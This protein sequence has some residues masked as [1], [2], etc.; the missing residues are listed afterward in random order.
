M[1]LP[2]LF[3][4]KD[5]GEADVILGI[6]IHKINTGFSLSQSHYIEKMLRKF[7]LFDV[8]PVRTPYDP[9][10]HLKKNKGSSVSQNEYTK[11]IESV[12]LLMNFTRPDIAYA[13]TRLS[14]YTYKL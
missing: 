14:R 8:T 3:E 4:M 13:I 10:I 7:N 12:M 11:I 5:M 2:L 9:G 1:L 6:K